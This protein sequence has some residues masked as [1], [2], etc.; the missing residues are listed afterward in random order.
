M[1]KKISNILSFTQKKFLLDVYYNVLNRKKLKSYNEYKYSDEKKKFTHILEA[2]NYSRVTKLDP[3]FFEF[4]CYSAR[5]FSAAIRSYLFFD[6]KDFKVFAF[7]SFEGLPF[8]SISDD[9][10]FKE[11]TFSMSKNKFIKEIKKNTKF[12]I[13]DKYI[14]EGFYDKTLNKS[15]SDKLP[16]PS[17]IHIDVDLYSST[18]I[19]LEFL[20]PLLIK[21]TLILFDDWYCFNPGD[22]LGERK[23]FKEFQNK[24]PNIKFENWKNYST[25]GKSFF[26]IS[27]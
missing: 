12:K 3:I 16:K 24:N 27:I 23:A 22:D 4:G 14:I 11:G 5:T 10:I 8:T 1:K 6:I 18:K 20:K 9:G 19:I 7:D 15:L 21:G 26:V 25:F 17:V 2:I 13:E